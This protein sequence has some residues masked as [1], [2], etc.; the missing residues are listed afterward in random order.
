MSQ[1]KNLLA[2]SHYID[3]V[4]KAGVA[5][6]TTA[7]IALAAVTIAEKIVQKIASAP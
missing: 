2:T 4:K 1:L 3:I 7:G 6:A 5:L